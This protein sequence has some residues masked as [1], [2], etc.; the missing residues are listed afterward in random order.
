MKKILT[1]LLALMAI[2]PASAD[3]YLTFGVNDSVRIKP[4]SLGGVQGLMMRAHFDGRLDKWDM[5]MQLPEGMNLLIAYRRNDMLYIPYQDCNGDNAYCSAQLFYVE[6]NNTHRDSLSASIIEYGWWDFNN[7]DDYEVYG[8]VKWEAG[9]YDQM[10]EL[11]Y[12]FNSSFPDTA[13]IVISE[14][15]SST[16]DP[17]SFTI[18]ETNLEKTIILYV[19]YMRGD[20]NGDENINIDDVSALTDYMNGVYALDKYQLA[21]ADVDGNGTIGIADLGSLIDLIL[22]LA[23]GANE[24]EDPTL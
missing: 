16:Y 6:N 18:P 12:T 17:R 21:A 3:R 24:I 23:A 19:G 20:V 8:T 22:E 2:L 9:D 15:L 10:C 13:S 4:S 14:H 5:T 11:F 7:D 1:L